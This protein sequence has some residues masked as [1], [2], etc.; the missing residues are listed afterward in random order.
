MWQPGEEHVAHKFTCFVAP[1][2]GVTRVN[3]CALALKLAM[4]NR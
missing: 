3:I 1:F 4:K 2:T